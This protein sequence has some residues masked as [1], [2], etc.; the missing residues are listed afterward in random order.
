MD[1]LVD[2]VYRR[3]YPKPESEKEALRSVIRY[4]NPDILVLQEMGD[5]PFIKELQE[6]L[7]TDGVDYPYAAY[8]EAT[9]KERHV[10]IL[11]REP[12]KEVNQYDK[13][14]FKHLGGARQFVKRGLI[15]AVFN[16]SGYEWSLFAVHLKSRYSKGS[17]DFESRKW[18]IGE[19]TVLRNLIREK[20]RAFI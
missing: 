14:S 8:V 3:D 13:L 11:S 2:G 4:A 12:F 19:A 20:V 18:R 1:R 17:Q 9:D 6:D 5:V 7:R 16:T 10:V 15:E